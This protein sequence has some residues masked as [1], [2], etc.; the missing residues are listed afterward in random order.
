[1]APAA[2][3]YRRLEQIWPLRSLGAGIGSVGIH[4]E[5]ERRTALQRGDRIELPAA[6]RGL[7]H[8]VARPQKKNRIDDRAREA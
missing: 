7:E 4:G 1:M 6:E 3:I 5:I 2:I 8:A